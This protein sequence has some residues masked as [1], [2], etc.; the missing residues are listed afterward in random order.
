MAERVD[1]LFGEYA[2]AYARGER[3]QAREF[4]VRAG[5]QVDELANLI[6]AFLAR[7]PAPAP[8]KQAVELFEAWQAGESPLLWLRTARGLTR[9]AIVAALVQTLGLDL[10]KK[11]KVRRY[12]HELESGQLEPE[13]V[14]G[15]VWDVLGETLG[16][17]VVDLLA[18]RP[19]RPAFPAPA[20]VRGPTRPMMT[21]T[22]VPEP[23]EE[24]AEDEVDRLFKSR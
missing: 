9:D 15:R 19:R 8:D 20:L 4:L 6:D 1:E 22:R 5:G 14:D 16:A 21:A 23:Q 13:R 17:R 18:W 3:P 10:K 7:A 11:E 24:P 12:Y 2:S